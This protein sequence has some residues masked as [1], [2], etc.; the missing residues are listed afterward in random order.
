VA[1]VIRLAID[2]Y[3]Q[4]NAPLHQNWLDQRWLITWSADDKDKHRGS[5]GRLRRED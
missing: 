3:Q 1:E 2:Q 4:D 5:V